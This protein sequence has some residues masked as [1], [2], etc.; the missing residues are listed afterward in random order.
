MNIRKLYR[1]PEVKKIT[2][3][4]L[5]LLIAAIITISAIAFFITRNI[6]K[7]IIENNTIIISKFTEKMDIGDIISDLPKVHNKEDFSK[8]KEVMKSY[9]YDDEMSKD[10]NELIV[11]FYKEIFITFSIFFIIIFSILYF[12]YI[13]ELKRIYINIDD[14]VN[15]VSSMSYGEYKSI[16][17]DFNEG[18]MAILISSL[19]YMGERVNNSINLLTKEKENLKDYLSD[20]SHQLKTPLSSLIMLND[21]LKENED[22]PYT[23]RIKFLNKCD[24]QLS[25]ME[26][27]I[28]NLLKVGRLEAGAVVFQK[29]LE[30]LNETINIAISSL[31]ETIKSKS[32]NLV[33]TGDLDSELLHDKEWLAEAFTNIIKNSVEHTKEGGEIKIEVVNGPLITKV[34]IKDNGKGIPKEMQKN[35]FK[36]FYKGENSKDP[37]SIGIGLSLS[38]TII[39]G[40]GGEIKVDSE[41]GKGTTFIISFLRK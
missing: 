28:M 27:L 22:M 37:K 31:K 2:I 15:K 23:D 3:K 21:L 5:L 12:F 36:R 30:P 33:I 41:E 8:A 9:G 39:E 34:Y 11:Y 40:L 32:Q 29:E 19:N 16:E 10:S 13:R 17:G 38:K 18:D 25:R 14:I 24:E 7:K 1:N 4:Y 6:N 26:W 20:I 35:I